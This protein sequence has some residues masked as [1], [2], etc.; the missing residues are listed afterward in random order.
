MLRILLFLV[1]LLL[2]LALLIRADTL[3]RALYV[4][5]GAMVLYAV[6]KTTGVIDAIA[7]DRIGV[8]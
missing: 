5:L 1:A 7:P 4:V 3:R 8:F 6:L 2:L